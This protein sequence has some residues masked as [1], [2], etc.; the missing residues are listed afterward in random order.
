VS[1]SSKKS[2]NPIEM[3]LAAMAISW[4]RFLLHFLIF[5]GK[6]LDSIG[7]LASCTSNL[8]IVSMVKWI[9]L[10]QLGSSIIFPW[11]FFGIS[12]HPSP[13][14]LPTNPFSGQLSELEIYAID[15][16]SW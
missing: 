16:M 12:L 6:S 15:A 9:S 8:S 5:W 14:L 10:E 13:A 11:H 7:Q 1:V 4:N 2:E 3:G